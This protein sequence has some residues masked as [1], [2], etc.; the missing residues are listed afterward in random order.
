[1]SSEKPRSVLCSPMSEG[2]LQV[3]DINVPDSHKY[4]T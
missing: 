2:Q 4:G 3:M 1:M